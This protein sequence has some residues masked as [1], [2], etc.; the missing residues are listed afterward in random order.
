VLESLERVLGARPGAG[1]QVEMTRNDELT[2]VIDRTGKRIA[3]GLTS[4]G[5]AVLAGVVVSE[6]RKARR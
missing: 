4:A 1:L 5:A 3:F 2:R 6:V